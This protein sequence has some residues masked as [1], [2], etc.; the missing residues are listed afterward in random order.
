MS[1]DD[2]HEQAP[3]NVVNCGKW[4]GVFHNHGGTP[5]WTV[6]KGNSHLEMN[7]N[8]WEVDGVGATWGEVWNKYTMEKI[9]SHGLS[10]TD[11][12]TRKLLR[13]LGCEHLIKSPSIC[14]LMCPMHQAQALQEASCCGSR[15]ERLL[16]HPNP[17]LFSIII[18][19]DPCFSM[20][21]HLGTSPPLV[22]NL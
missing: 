2:N 4:S 14:L 6:Y 3:Q 15:K 1:C 20:F 13:Y 5:R 19:S 16:D 9:V 21:F 10:W 17:T 7:D 18:H 22:L 12:C 8:D 11:E